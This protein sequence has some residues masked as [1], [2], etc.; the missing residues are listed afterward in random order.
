MKKLIICL[1][2]LVGLT[3]G[4]KAQESGQVW[5]GG[6]VGASS[7]K[8]KDGIRLNQFNIIPEAGYMFTD[9]WGVGIKLGYLHNENDRD[10]FREKKDGLVVNP[11]ARYSFLKSDLGNLFIDGGVGYSYLKNQSSAL[12]THEI[13]VGFR[14]GVAINVS[15][16]VTLTGKYGFLGYQYEKE[17]DR[18]TNTFGLDFDLSQIQLGM[19]FTF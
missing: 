16:K 8:V 6:S 4:M 17:D 14:P 2:L 5:L 3:T 13:E 9:S 12:K 11:F 19:I 7:S 18:K 1:S 15:D 10:G